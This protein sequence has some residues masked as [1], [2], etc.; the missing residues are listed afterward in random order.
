MGN[1]YVKPPREGNS[2][3][4]RS[5]I[6]PPA[7]LKKSGSDKPSHRLNDP[8]SLELHMA[9]ERVR[10]AG[11][12][13][14][15]REWRMKWIKDQHLHPDEPIV[16]DAVHRQLNPIRVLYRWPWDKFYLHCLKPTF[17]VYYGTAIR[18]TVPKLFMAFVALETMYYYWKYEVKDWQHLRG[19]ETMPLKEVIVNEKEI[20]EKYPGLKAK[21]L[22]DPAKHVECH[23]IFPDFCVSISAS[24]KLHSLQCVY[25]RIITGFVIMA[26]QVFRSIAAEAKRIPTWDVET[27]LTRAV[28]RALNNNTQF[29]Q[30]LDHPPVN[31][32]KLRLVAEKLCKRVER[33]YEK[34][35]LHQRERD[36][37]ETD[38]KL[39][40][41]RNEYSEQMEVRRRDEKENVLEITRKSLET[42]L[43]EL[44]LS[45]EHLDRAK[46]EFHAKFTSDVE[47][48]NR[49]WERLSGKKEELR[50]VFK[51]EFEAEQQ[52]LKEKSLELEK[53]NIAL[54][55]KISESGT[56]LFELRSKLSRVAAVEED[57][58]I[59][60]ERLRKETEENH[61][62]SRLKYEIERLREENAFLKEEIEQLKSISREPK[63]ASSLKDSSKFPGEEVYQVKIRELK[64]IIKLMN[65]KIT[66]VSSERDYLRDMLRA[67]RKDVFR[68]TVAKKKEHPVGKPS[69]TYRFIFLFPKIRSSPVKK[70]GEELSENPGI[71]NPSIYSQEVPRLGVQQ[72]EEE[73]ETP[74]VVDLARRRSSADQ[75]TLVSLETAEEH[76]TPPRAS[77]EKVSNDPVP[78]APSFAERL[79]ARNEASRKLKFSLDPEKSTMEEEAESLQNTDPSGSPD[80]PMEKYMALITKQGANDEQRPTSKTDQPAAASLPFEVEDVHV[81]K[82]GDSEDEIEW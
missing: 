76:R 18:V 29:A 7:I 57:L 9:D 55:K 49:E 69:T 26:D 38:R 15:E 39:N 44:T 12:S 14:A 34:R 35:L 72:H 62:L 2:P 36:R 77:V 81:D 8:M 22:V 19:I 13:P 6:P 41:I 58:Q 75:R 46:A 23:S 42:R 16:V 60:N 51:Q 48:L 45:K 11:L 20:E 21:A 64:T 52:Q 53:E 33:R 54:K 63:A 24:L 28:Y 74:R 43:T 32:D 65:D 47:M 40:D 3:Y 1:Q 71:S 70:V 79:R 78:A 4:T 59:A 30:A 25:D 50:S 61:R 56:E 27:I 37:A 67:A 80:N 73:D 31:V 66:S 5:G 17:G 10:A 68:E 82:P